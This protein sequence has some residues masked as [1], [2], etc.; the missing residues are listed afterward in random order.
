MD[1]RSGSTRG[2]AIADLVAP[3]VLSWNLR[4][5]LWWWSSGMYRLYG[6]ETDAIE[7][8]LSLLLVHQHPDDRD[9][10]EQALR[11]TGRDGRPFIFEHR[12]VTAGEQVRTL[13]LSVQTQLGPGGR[14]GLISG[15]SLDVSRVRRMHHAAADE[16]VSG[17][18]AELSRLTTAAEARGVINQ[19][20]GILVER[21]RFTAEQATGLLRGASQVACRSLADVA[22]EL[23]FTG[24][25]PPGSLTCL[26]VPS[27]RRLGRR[28]SEPDRD[29]QLG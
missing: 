14:P 27:Q 26:Q 8:C 21:H 15:I 3:A 20:I 1:A 18:Q 24:K 5:D 17:L 16:T 25:L 13:I 10:M 6:Y 23:V 9:R 29:A 7:P 12:I 11:R 28:R 22:S 2:R 19:A 4:T